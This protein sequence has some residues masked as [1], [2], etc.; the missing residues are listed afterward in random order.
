MPTVFITGAN[1]GLGLE[2]AKQ[3]K[4]A[5]WEV[6]ATCRQPEK[7]TGLN[8]LGVEVL[9]LDVRDMDAI[10]ALKSR[11]KG[12]ALDLVICNAGVYGG[13]QA[14]G[15]SSPSEWLEVLTVNVIAPLKV[16]EA[17]RGNLKAARNPKVA[18]MTSL[19]GSMD[20]N[21]SGGSYIY[22]SSKAGLNAV[23]R[24]LSLDLAQDGIVVVLLHP[25]WVRTD[26]GGPH[27]LIDPP[28]SVA[29]LRRVIE[30]TNQDNSGRFVAYDGEALD[31]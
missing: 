28:E 7:A 6:V 21:T 5:G 16:V 31:W 20:D 26:M 11:M 27:G 24:S 19:M 23:G 29:G 1:R 17:L 2:F 14:L 25:G 4:D 18:L 12:R 22:R 10:A 30:G 8:A 15:Q 13:D 9:G 3:Y